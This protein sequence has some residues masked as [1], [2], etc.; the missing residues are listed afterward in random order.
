MSDVLVLSPHLD[1]AVFSASHAVMSGSAVVT[2]FAG[3]PVATASG[4]WDRI[5]GFPSSS[6]AVNARRREDHQALALLGA[7][8]STHF[9]LTENQYGSPLSV[10]DLV[11][12][13]Q[14]AIEPSHSE[15]LAPIG[16]GGH[17]DHVLVRDAALELSRQRDASIS[18]YADLPYAVQHGWPVE[19]SGE[20]VEHCDPMAAWSLWV[21]ATP[22]QMRVIRLDEEEQRQKKAAARV[23]ASQWNAV[24]GLG[25]LDHPAFWAYEVLW[26]VAA[27]GTA[28]DST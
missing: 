18:L 4:P 16:I 23:Y 19:V 20:R 7:H 2:V 3:F 14:T 22:G 24:S 17:P 26:D 6:E 21:P 25:L 11:S 28:T 15:L 9:D 27:A 13:L 12:A 5:C 8:S 1:D 10:A